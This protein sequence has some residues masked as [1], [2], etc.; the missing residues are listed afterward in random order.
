VRGYTARRPPKLSSKP[1]PDRELAYA[2]IVSEI[3]HRYLGSLR[4]RFNCAFANREI[5]NHVAR[6]VFTH[7]FPGRDMSRLFDASHNTEG[8]T[9]HILDGKSELFSYIAGALARKACRPRLAQ[10]AKLC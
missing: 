4:A 1:F 3:G 10:W 5:L 8:R 2:P 9:P 6:R 7:F